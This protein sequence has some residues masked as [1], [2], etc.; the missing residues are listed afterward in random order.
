MKKLFSVLPLG[1]TFVTL[2][3]QGQDAPPPAMAQ[4]KKLTGGVWRE[5][6]DKLSSEFRYTLNQDGGVDGAVS[7]TFAD[8]E[9]H[10][11]VQH[12]GVDPKT[13]AVWAMVI[14][15]SSSVS[16]GH[17][18]V[19][20]GEMIWDLKSLSG[21]PSHLIYKEHFTDANTYISKCYKVAADGKRELVQ[22]SESVRTEN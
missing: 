18:S 12:F 6:T 22:T 8:G 15:D 14:S 10:T 4:L 9:K 16:F 13:H 7:I 17:G 11:A 19:V 5:K 3:A 1:L 2:A 21:E 20:D